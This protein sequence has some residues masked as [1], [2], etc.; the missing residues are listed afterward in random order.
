MKC[1][2]IYFRSFGRRLLLPR[3]GFAPTKKTN[4]LLWVKGHQT[5]LIDRW[6]FGGIFCC[7]IC[8]MKA[9]DLHVC[10]QHLRVPCS[11]AFLRPWKPIQTIINENLA[12][13]WKYHI[14]DILLKMAAMHV[15][16]M[17][18]RMASLI[19]DT[20]VTSAFSSSRQAYT[21]ISSLIDGGCVWYF[22]VN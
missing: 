6:H 2:W 19:H 9:F 7:L 17:L 22:L 16:Q 15:W 18:F 8:L 10:A 14:T 5:A 1:F 4:R 3:L 11:H 20:Y 12:F 21:N 13:I